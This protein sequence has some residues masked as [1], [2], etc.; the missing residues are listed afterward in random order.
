[1]NFK[2]NIAQGYVFLKSFNE[3]YLPTYV[4]NLLI[5]N[6]CEQKNLHFNLSVNEHNIKNCWM[7]LFSI[8]NNKNTNIIVMTSIYMLPN[9]TK[10]FERFCKILK[11]NKKEFFFIFENISAKNLTQLKKLKQ[12]FNL[13]KKLNQ[14]I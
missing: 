8:I 5:K 13:F 2:K 9:N 3:I 4:Q 1:M 11:K 6:F 14:F 12:K 7:E 10:D